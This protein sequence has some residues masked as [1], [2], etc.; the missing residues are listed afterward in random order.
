MAKKESFFW[1][2]YSDLMTSMFF[3]MLVLFVCVVA[4]LHRRMTD[5]DAE[6]K[7]TTEQLR[8]IKEIEEATHTIDTTYFEYRPEYKKHVLKI[9]VQFQTGSSNIYDVDSITREKL[10]EAGKAI[11]KFIKRIT[12]EHPEVQYLLV[13]EGQTSSDNYRWN[14]DLSYERALALKQL[15]EGNRYVE[16]NN[17]NKKKTNKNL[18]SY[19]WEIVENDSNKIN[20]GD[21]CEVVIGGNGDGKLSGTGF[22]RETIESKNQ[23]FLIHILPK[24]S[25]PEK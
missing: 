7:A 13:I 10:M 4:L 1:T 21:K 14:Y 19:Y 25:I 16:I 17:N 24:T 9:Q 8:V 6:R 20:F 22:M 5:I 23:R 2:S 15:W 18:K 12:E 11:Q 3:V